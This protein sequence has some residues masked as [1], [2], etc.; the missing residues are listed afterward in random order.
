MKTFRPEIILALEH[1]ILRWP[2]RNSI[3][4]NIFGFKLISFFLLLD[5]RNL[6]KKL[7]I[8]MKTLVLVIMIL[9]QLINYHM[10]QGFL[11]NIKNK[12]IK[13]KISFA[14]GKR[15]KLYKDTEEPGPGHYIINS[16][17]QGPKVPILGRHEII[18]SLDKITPGPGNYFVEDGIPYKIKG[19]LM[20][21]TKKNNSSIK[22]LRNPGPGP[23]QYNVNT[24]LE[25]SGPKY[26]YLKMIKKRIN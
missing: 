20:S 15:L 21:K 1:I 13:K 26:T 8:L 7:I 23:G 10:S 19:S 16:V 5:S 18:Q 24:S 17:N 3:K 6:R 9:T 25:D 14:T 4:G 12:N 2:L 11:Y 22:D